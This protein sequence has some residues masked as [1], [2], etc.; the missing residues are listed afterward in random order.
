MTVL[1]MGV[2]VVQPSRIEAAV[3]RRGQ[4]LLRRIFTPGELDYCSRGRNR[5]QRLAARFAAKEAALKALGTGLAGAA[6][7]TDVE[8]IHL[9]RRAP[10]IRLHREVARRADDMGVSEVKVSLSHSGDTAVAVV[11]LLGGSGEI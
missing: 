7:W 8:V 9:R 2:D 6:R 11:L 10:A 4:A 3:S 5:Y 1:G